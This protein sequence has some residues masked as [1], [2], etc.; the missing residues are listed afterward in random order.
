M[1]IEPDTKDWTWV[2][3]R[4]C[5]DCGF[6]ASKVE[7]EWIPSTVRRIA[8][9]WQLVL[10][11]VDVRRRPRP[12]TWSPLEY[13]CHVRDVLRVFDGR[14]ELMLT[15]HGPRFPNWDQDQTAMRD[16]YSIQDPVLVAGELTDA[17]QQV[18]ARLARVSGRDW[19]RPGYRSNGS[20]FTVDSLARYML[21]D[22]EHHLVD[23]GA[24]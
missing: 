10:I 14:F 15:E 13:G 9:D 19:Q 24:R 11:R 8:A 3:Q 6:D 1:S 12:A 17:A 7:L 22:L 20:V 2:L 21:H 5:E 4:P 23:V 16:R 18:A